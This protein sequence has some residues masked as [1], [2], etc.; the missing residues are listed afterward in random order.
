MRDARRMPVRE[1]A[2]AGGERGGGAYLDARRRGGP[3]RASLTV[4]YRIGAPRGAEKLSDRRPRY[5]ANGGGRERPGE[6]R[7]GGA[8]TH[9]SAYSLRRLA[10]RRML[11]SCALDQFARKRFS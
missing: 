2:G 4:C 1:R 5:R 10:I 9:L 8:R 11:D 7:E 3:L 6:G